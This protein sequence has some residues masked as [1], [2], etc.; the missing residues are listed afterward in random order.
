MFSAD[1]KVMAY[2]SRRMSVSV[3]L[4]IVMCGPRGTSDGDRAVT[5]SALLRPLAQQQ[6]CLVI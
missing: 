2:V 4:Q 6:A 1:S 3:C 5:N